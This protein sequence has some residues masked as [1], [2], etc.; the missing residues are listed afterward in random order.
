MAKKLGLKLND[1]IVMYFVQQPPRARK[2]KVQGIY[3]TSIEE[4]DKVFVLAD[5]KQIQQLNNW[6]DSQIGGYE[7]F[8]D[9]FEKMDEINE[10]IRYMADVDQD[11]KTIRE[12]Y[13]QIF[14]WLG[15]LNVNVEIILSLMGLVA[16]I[17][18]ITALLIMI[19]ERTQMI[20]VFKALGASD[21]RLQ[22]IFIFNAMALIVLGLI[23][24][25]VAALGMLALQKQ[26]H[27]IKLSQESYYLP[28]VPVFFSW[29]RILLINFGAFI[30][31]SFATFLPS[32]LVL[33]VRPSKSLRFE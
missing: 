29:S 1:S 16:A 11:T 7:I 3:E 33:R 27:I 18:M 21:W 17:N 28:S 9:G 14:D 6:K 23:I 10:D 31:C 4:I 15:L 24:G 26:F 25:N 22:K 13:P 30:F 32:L 5:L 19:L 12:R 8:L 2:L 20:G